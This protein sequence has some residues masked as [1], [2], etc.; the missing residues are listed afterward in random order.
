MYDSTDVS[1][2]ITTYKD[3]DIVLLVSITDYHAK[4]HGVK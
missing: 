4:N 1:I 3:C 2:V